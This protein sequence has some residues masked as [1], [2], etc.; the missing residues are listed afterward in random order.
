MKIE[1]PF[2]GDKKRFSAGFTLIELLTVIAI[3]G[4]LAAILIPVLGRTRDQARQSVCASNLRQVGI[5]VHMYAADN[6]DWLPPVTRSASPFTT[7]WMTNGR[8]LGLLMDGGYVD[9]EEVFF[10]PTR[11]VD[12]NEALGYSSPGN[13][14]ADGRRERSSFPARYFSSSSPAHWKL[15]GLI[16][17]PS[18]GPIETMQAVIYSDFVGVKNFQGGGI[19]GSRIGEVHEGRGFNRLFGD[20]SVRWTAPGPLTSRLSSGVSGGILERYYEEL[21]YLP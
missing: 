16:D 1:K 2:S 21:D 10:C 6:G 3:I 7:Y 12:P 11:D 4:I 18:L 9:N 5:G 8:N 15:T 14:T 20:G 13:I 19:T 17:R